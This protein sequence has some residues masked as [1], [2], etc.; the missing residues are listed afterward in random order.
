MFAITIF[1]NEFSSEQ[2]DFITLYAV[3]YYSDLHFVVAYYTYT[4]CH[5]KGEGAIVTHYVRQERL[6][7]IFKI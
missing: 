5:S 7:P 1:D 4:G 6:I 3:R 2:Q